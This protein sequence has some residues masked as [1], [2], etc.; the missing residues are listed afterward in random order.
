MT[1]QIIDG[2]KIANSLLEELKEEITKRQWT[3]LW[4]GRG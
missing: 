4:I 2:K 1:A 3:S